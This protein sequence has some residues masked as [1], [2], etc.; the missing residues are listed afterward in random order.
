MKILI[1]NDLSKTLDFKII[2]D[3]MTKTSIDQAS[4][5]STVNQVDFAYC[6]TE[7]H[8]YQFNSIILDVNAPDKTR[9]KMKLLSKIVDVGYD[10]II[11]HSQ[12]CS[13]LE[14][15]C[16]RFIDTPKIIFVHDCPIDLF[17]YISLQKNIVKLKQLNCKIVTNSKYTH[18]RLN[19]LYRER[20]LYYGYEYIEQ[21]CDM[22]SQ[23]FT[24][25]NA[26]PTINNALKY[27]TNIGRI[28]PFKEPQRLLGIHKYSNHG[29]H[30]FGR[31]DVFEPLALKLYQKIK[32]A[33][34]LYPNYHIHINQEHE[35]INSY[36]QNA[37][38]HVITW[39]NEGFGYTALEAGIYGV[40]SV[41]VQ[42]YDR[43]ATAEH[44]QQ[45]GAAYT[46]VDYKDRRALYDIVDQYSLTL[47][48]RKENS[49]KFLQYY[50]LENYI[51]DLH[52]IINQTRSTL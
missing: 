44:L 43:H 6:G 42:R 2:S 49:I 18:D 38:N 25:I 10:I 20:L 40:P 37:Q 52:I 9:D 32:T 8:D 50:T 11:I 35:Y 36:L 22:Y 15:F 4:A 33:T 1:V 51:K 14:Q 5:L 30:F 46:I 16:Q 48:Q 7:H 39:T 23:C 45:I 17:M 41:I 31:L 34:E 24:Y 21:V 3:G 19:N 12:R 47:E 13:K 27:S 29:I 26:Q 28:H